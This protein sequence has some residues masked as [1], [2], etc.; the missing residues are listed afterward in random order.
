MSSSDHGDDR[1]RLKAMQARTDV[2]AAA[3]LLAAFTC[4][5]LSTA[6]GVLEYGDDWSML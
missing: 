5:Y 2:A 1:R 6:K 3:W 4:L